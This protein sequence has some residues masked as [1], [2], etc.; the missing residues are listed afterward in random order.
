[1]CRVLAVFLFSFL[2]ACGDDVSSSRTSTIPPL[3]SRHPTTETPS[4]LP[5]NGE[6]VYVGGNGGLWIANADGSEAREVYDGA[7]GYAYRPEWSPTG[8]RIAFTVIAYS[9]STSLAYGDVASIV[10][11]DLAGSVLTK[12]PGFMPRWPPDGDR[13][14]FLDGL[15]VDNEEFVGVPSIL[16]LSDDSVNHVTSQIPTADSPSWSPDG[17]RIAFTDSAKGLFLFEAEGGAEA[18]RLHVSDATGLGTLE[19]ISWELLVVFDRNIDNDRYIVVNVDTGE[20][21]EVLRH[22]AFQCGRTWGPGDGQPVAIADTSLVVWPTQ[23]LDPA[24]PNSSGVWIGETMG[25]D[26]SRFY[27]IAPGCCDRIEVLPDKR[28]LIVSRGS[29]L[30]IR[31]DLP[32]FFGNEASVWILNIDSGEAA[33]IVGAGRDAAAIP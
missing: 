6:I 18:R 5:S 1:M 19:W 21:T 30:T 24:L 28:H 33:E 20:E 16:N 7:G 2:M 9:D 23:C 14:T 11:I 25:E 10:V 26:A 12:T 29:H 17:K 3:A 15:D 31:P 13:L 32:P 22:Q 8:N 27:P 4:D